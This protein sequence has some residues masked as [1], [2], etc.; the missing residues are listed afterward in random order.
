[1]KISGSHT[2]QAILAEIGA[3]LSRHRLNLGLTQ[4]EA[5]N[6]AGIAKRTVERIETGAS[7]QTSSLVRLLRALGLLA[8]ID[9][10]VRESAPSPI[11]LMKLKGKERQRASSRRPP[12][13][14]TRD[15]SWSDET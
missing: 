2:D 9:T 12:S 1:M 14:P 7:A 3:R 10:L 11:E 15:W 13:G 6:Q 4:E 5:A 8:G